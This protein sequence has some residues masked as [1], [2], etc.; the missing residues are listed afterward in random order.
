MAQLKCTECG[1]VFN[2]TLD[3][4]PN[5]GCPA[6]ECS[7][8]RENKPQS[9]APTH[10]RPKQ[11]ANKATKETDEDY[12]TFSELF[13]SCQFYKIVRGHTFDL[14][15]RF[16]EFGVFIWECIVVCWAC[17]TSKFATFSG[18]ATRRE[19]FSFCLGFAIIFPIIETIWLLVA[20]S[21]GAFLA[22]MGFYGT[23]AVIATFIPMGIVLFIFFIPLLAVCAR[24]MHDI[25]KGFWWSLLIFPLFKQSDK[26]ENAYGSIEE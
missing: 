20:A 26:G 7:P 12:K 3:A 15:Q 10:Q 18:R 21:Y 22:E 5:C 25:G 9:E 17:I 11:E 1:N 4:C 6:S 19:Y 24:R 16:Y 2:D 14:G 23:E 8:I 13:W